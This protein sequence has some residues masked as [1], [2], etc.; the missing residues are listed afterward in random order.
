MREGAGRVLGSI[1]GAVYT[2]MLLPV[3]VV[4][5]VSFSAD[6]FIVFPPSGVSLRWYGQLFGNEA[7]MRGLGLSLRLA[8]TVSL[9]SLALGVPA[10]FAI[11]RG[12]APGARA[13]KAFFLAPLLLP[14]L[15]LGLALLMALQPLRLTATF[16][17]LAMGHMLV[18]LP[19][20]IRFMV[21][22]FATLPDDVEAAAAS[23]GAGPWRAFIRV[24][25]PLAAPGLLASGF[26]AFLLSFDETVISLFLSGPIAAP[27]SVEMVRYVEG[28]TDPLVAALS[29]ILITGTI[30]VILLVERIA[31]VMRVVGR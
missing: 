21:T 15:V 3:A 22:A 10:A 20:V 25:L 27:L 14:T 5:L 9:L 6:S 23:L 1:A 12:L 11:Q 13:L 17:G 8:A 26:L 28:R 16:A 24:T 29:V 2:L 4:A 30:A 18:T 19:F 7:L 31:G